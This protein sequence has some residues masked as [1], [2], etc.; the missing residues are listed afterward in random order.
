MW[1]QRDSPV[2]NVPDS[3]Q[4]P[5]QPGP[6]EEPAG[7]VESDDVHGLQREHCVD[8]EVHWLQV[9]LQRRNNMHLVVKETFYTSG[10]SDCMYLA[11]TMVSIEC[12]ALTLNALVV[13]HSV[14]GSANNML[15]SWPST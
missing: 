5:S 8:V 15:F 11:N 2:K 4:D 6:T 13:G 12:L 1:L 9:S 10:Q 14:P 3:S 7:N